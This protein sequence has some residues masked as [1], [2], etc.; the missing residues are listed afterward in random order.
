MSVFIFDSYRFTY[1]CSEGAKLALLRLSYGGVL[2]AS[3]LLPIFSSDGYLLINYLVSSSSPMSKSC[4]FCLGVSAGSMPVGRLTRD[5]FNYLV[6]IDAPPAFDAVSFLGAA[7]F[8]LA[9]ASALI[10][11]HDLAGPSA[12]AGCWSNSSLSKLF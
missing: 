6:L 8:L 5:G 2:G 11:F 12:S 4:S 3:V 9:I 10:C 1:G 7:V